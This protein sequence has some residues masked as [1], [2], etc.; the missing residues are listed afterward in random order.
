MTD[1]C[2]PC[3]PSVGLLGKPRAVGRA[4]KGVLGLLWDP[5]C[6]RRGRPL[7]SSRFC[8]LSRAL[9]AWAGAASSVSTPLSCP[10]PPAHVHAASK[11][12]PHAAASSSPPSRVAASGRPGVRESRRLSTPCPA[13]CNVDFFN[14]MHRAENP[15]EA[16]VAPSMI[17]H[18]VPPPKNPNA[19]PGLSS[20][21]FQ[22]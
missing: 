20:S 3:C 8:S 12:I 15:N 5:A 9:V 19:R 10:R 7:S 16:T 17:C 2:F 14:T 18:P 11:P 1:P 13:G 22:N 21:G 6:W 4:S